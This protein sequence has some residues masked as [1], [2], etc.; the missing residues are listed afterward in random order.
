MVRNSWSPGRGVACCDLPA[1]N[2]MFVSWTPDPMFARQTLRCCLGSGL[3]RPVHL[4]GR[5]VATCHLFSP[6]TA[7]PPSRLPPL[8][9]RSLGCVSLV[10]VSQCR[11]QLLTSGPPSQT[12][13]QC[14]QCWPLHR[15]RQCCKQLL[16]QVAPP[17]VPTL[18]TASQPHGP[19]CECP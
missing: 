5:F 18:Q 12:P 14:W 7:L 13:M 17:P 11:K 19:P 2:Q 4:K 1:D 10:S 6:S 16:I 9:R 8:I 3:E 15:P